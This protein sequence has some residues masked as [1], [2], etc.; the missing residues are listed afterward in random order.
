MKK[1][2]KLI[3]L[4]LDGTVFNDNKNITDRTKNAIA[5]AIEKG[6]VVLPSTGRPYTGVPEAFLSI[7]GVKYALTSNGAVIQDLVNDKPIYQDLMDIDLTLRILDE[8]SSYNSMLEVYIK[9]R[10]YSETEKLNVALSYIKDPAL[11]KYIMEN[12]V[13]VENLREY[14]IEQNQQIEKVHLLFSDLDE[15]DKVI[16]KL[17]KFHEI[18]I[19]SALTNNLEI[20]K[21]TVNKGN[22]LIELGKLLGINKDEIMACGDGGN[23]IEMIKNV[24]FGVAMGN[25]IEEVKEVADYVTLTNEEDGVADAIEKFAL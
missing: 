6:I 8:V 18:V 1:N 7:P 21:N 24:G 5:K 2:I 17:E 15:K 10:G 23:D 14:M 13:G 9:G 4:D 19:T 22:G 25:A 12:R 11:A 20:N 16:K 3:G